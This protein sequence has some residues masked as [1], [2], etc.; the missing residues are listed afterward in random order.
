MN[1]TFSIL[2]AVGQFFICIMIFVSDRFKNDMPP[3]KIKR[4]FNIGYNYAKF[5]TNC[6][7]AIVFSLICP[8]VTVIGKAF[9]RILILIR[10]HLD[11]SLSSQ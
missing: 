1:R 5:H 6:C 7:I 8:L 11:K 10:S 2:L 9:L 4:K 3:Q